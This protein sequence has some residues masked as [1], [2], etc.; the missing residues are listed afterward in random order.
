MLFDEKIEFSHTGAIAVPANS[1]DEFIVVS[2][3][4]IGVPLTATWTFRTSFL[5]EYTNQVP[6]D[7]DELMT[8]TTIGLGYRF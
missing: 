2:E 1:P 6:S 4:I 5:A 3:M 7:V 8:R